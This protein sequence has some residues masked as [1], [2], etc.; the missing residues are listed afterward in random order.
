MQLRITADWHCGRLLTSNT[1]Y[2][3]ADKR[4]YLERATQDL[5]QDMLVILGDGFDRNP[6]LTTKRQ[7]NRDAALASEFTRPLGDRVQYYRGNHDALQAFDDTYIRGKLG[8]DVV[9]HDDTPQ[10]WGYSG[11]LLAHGH[12]WQAE[13][14][15]NER[16]ARTL[17]EVADHGDTSSIRAEIRT[18]IG[19]LLEQSTHRLPES[20]HPQAWLGAMERSLRIIRQQERGMRRLLREVMQS[21]GLRQ[22]RTQTI[23]SR[24]SDAMQIWQA[25]QAAAVAGCDTAVIAHSHHAGIYVVPTTTPDLRVQ[26]VT[27]INPGTPVQKDWPMTMARVDVESGDAVLQYLSRHDRQLHTI[28]GKHQ[29]RGEPADIL[30]HVPTET[31]SLHD[32]P[33]QRT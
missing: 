18:C 19:H 13:H 33:P 22:S 1:M 27:V 10:E 31:A 6:D 4:A 14:R 5:A 23:L 7:R 16:L 28:M 32:A 15:A 3:P 26:D 24:A 11:V 25:A 12:Q 17:L 20:P 9:I 30:V 2:D 29:R 8:P 21:E